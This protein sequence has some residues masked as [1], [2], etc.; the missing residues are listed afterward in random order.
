MKTYQETLDF[1]YTQLPMY[2][3]VGKSAFKKDLTNTQALLK[4]LGNPERTFRSIHIA[5]TNGKGSSAA[6]LN[7]VLIQSGYCTGCYTSPHLKSFTE[8]ITIDG[9][10]IAEQE[11]IQFVERIKPQIETIQPSFFE[12]TVAMAFWYFSQQQVDIAVIETGLGGR[13][14][15]TN[16]ILPEVALI[17]K[18]G[19]DHKDMLGY[20]L[21]AIAGEKAGII[22]EKIPTVLG[23]DQPEIL[24]VFAEK[25]RSVGSELI[26]TRSQYHWEQ[27]PAR[28][29]KQVLDLYVRD[30]LIYEALELNNAAA[31]VS[32]NLPGVLEVLRILQPGFPSINEQSI[33]RGL[34]HFQ[35]KGRMQVLGEQPLVIADV[36]H[37]EQGLQALFDQI[38]QWPYEKLRIILG[39]V[40]EKDHS[41]VLALLPRDA[42]YYFTQSQVPRSLPLSVLKTAALDAGIRGAAYANV[43][44]ALAAAKMQANETDCILIC[45]STFVVAEIE[46]L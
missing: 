5:G 38:G 11:V 4:E 1:L 27:R 26:T 22:K 40:R 33:R 35:L 24:H 13:L 14:D 36:S 15:S 29:G 7:S 2:Q 23:S 39:S 8:R 41:G 42:V 20:T 10:N 18:I 9:S 44:I 19:M 32:D 25:A 37:N 31:Y 17:T 28:L 46:D 43:N 34:A 16:V 6:M 30:E 12:I 21:E 3:K 45:G